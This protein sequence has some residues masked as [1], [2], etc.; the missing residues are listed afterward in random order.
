MFQIVLAATGVSV[1]FRLAN[2]D[3]ISRG[4]SEKDLSVYK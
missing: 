4:E 1:H 3:N 2:T